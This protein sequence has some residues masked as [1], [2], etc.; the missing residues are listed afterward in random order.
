MMPC[1]WV[2]HHLET[3][4]PVNPIRPPLS[5]LPAIAAFLVST[6]LSIVK[7]ELASWKKES[8]WGAVSCLSSGLVN[9]NTVHGFIISRWLT[10][11][12]REIRICLKLGDE[13]WRWSFVKRKWKK[14]VCRNFASV[15][16]ICSYVFMQFYMSWSLFVCA[17][18]TLKYF[19]VEYI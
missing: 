13:R 16:K 2:Q 7:S 4:T 19:V 9:F 1:W 3:F 6:Y 15:V 14:S 8:A 10:S 18:Q 12:V 17:H 5:S 11:A